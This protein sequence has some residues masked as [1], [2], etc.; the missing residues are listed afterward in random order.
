MKHFCLLFGFAMLFAGVSVVGADLVLR[1]PDGT[2]VT[3]DRDAYGVPHVRGVSE[4]GVFFGQ[5]FAA[6]ARGPL[7][8]FQQVFENRH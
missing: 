3:I 6:N 8:A 4:V 7:S 2:S 5:G 1:A